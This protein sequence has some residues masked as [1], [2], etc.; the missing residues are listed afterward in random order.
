MRHVTAALL[1]ICAYAFASPAELERAKQLYSRTQYKAALQLLDVLSGTADGPIHELIGKTHFMLG[2]Y[3][4]A[5]GAFAKAIEADPKNSEYHHWLGKAHGRRAETSNI[6]IA[7]GLASKAREA[8]EKAV[9]LNPRNIEAINDLFTY[10]LEAPGFL[11]GGLD[12]A[13]ALANRIQTI[14]PAEYH[15]ALAQIAEKRKE[16]KAA[17]DHLRQAMELAPRQVGRVIDLAKFLAKQGRQ[18]ESEAMFVQA[19]KV[20]PDSPRLLFERARSYLRSGKKEQARTLLQRYLNA[21][22]TPDDPSRAEAERLLKQAG[23]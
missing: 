19:E 14:D 16:F 1:V 22:L 18:E 8:F 10:Y 17:E 15:Y 12:K 21:P 5:A 11:G 4:K 20:A 6:F 2:D 7:P 13:S 23:A 3:K 9:E